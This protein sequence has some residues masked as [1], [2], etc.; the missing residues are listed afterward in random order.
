MKVLVN[1]CENCGGKLEII[2]EKHAFCPFCESEY[3]FK[4]DRS[5]AL[6]IALNR[7]KMKRL[8]NDFDGSITEYKLVLK[9]NPED[10]E[11]YWGLVLSTYGIEY[12]EDPRTKKMIPTCR[13]TIIRDILDDENYKKALEYSEHEQREQYEKNAVVISRLQKKI[14]RQ[15]EDE[16]DYTVFLSFKS[17]NEDGTPTRER[18]IAR[19]IYD[20]LTKRGIKTFFSEITLKNRIGEDF[21]P[22]IFKALYS[23]KYFILVA[24]SEENI[25]ATW[26]KNEWSRFRDRITDENLTDCCFAVFGDIPVSKLPAFIRK[27]GINL[28]KYPAGGYE[29]EIADALALKLGLINRNSESD[30]IRQQLEE[31]KRAQRE[32]EERLRSVTSTPRNENHSSTPS[33]ATYHKRAEQE[34][35]A[36][37]FSGAQSY[38]N[39]ILDIDPENAYAWLGLFYV[40]LK[41][42][43]ETLKLRTK[44][45]DI[46]DFISCVKANR[47]LIESTKKKYYINACRY[48]TDS[49]KKDI[50]SIK[51]KLVQEEGLFE[52]EAFNKFVLSLGKNFSKALNTIPNVCMKLH[53]LGLCAANSYRLLYLSDF[54]NQYK[55]LKRGQFCNVDEYEAVILDF[56]KIQT[57]NKFDSYNKMRKYNDKFSFNKDVLAFISSNKNYVLSLKSA[58][59]HLAEKYYKIDS[60]YHEIIQGE[61]IAK[62]LNNIVTGVNVLIAKNKE[63]LDNTQSGFRKK[64]KIHKIVDNLCGVGEFV[65]CLPKLFWVIWG[66]IYL[67]SILFFSAAVIAWNDL[68]NTRADMVVGIISIVAFSVFSLPIILIIMSFILKIVFA[69]FEKKYEM[70]EEKIKSYLDLENKYSELLDAT[71]QN[72]QTV[73]KAIQK[74]KEQRTD[75]SLYK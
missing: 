11:A 14:K 32:L 8:D 62:A 7:A 6:N 66:V 21:E 50:E 33:T 20:E 28:A 23:C 54:E 68:D 42:V 56:L 49:Q 63:S 44:Y 27:Q 45:S 4:D 30:E 72:L 52:K 53:A 10:A 13:R 18:Y 65:L 12:V 75:I 25:N 24:T 17:A 36:K 69:R 39:K 40:D 67:I 64:E 16:E 41:M 29:I 5:D 22:I 37:N 73:D 74:E 2:D 47:A 60:Q 35:L 71:K 51:Q 59:D 3:F 61:E 31:Q 15:L 48:A 43:P 70:L 1:T 57:P 58:K 55:L 34:L 9:D 46:D 38:Y 26:V 19:K